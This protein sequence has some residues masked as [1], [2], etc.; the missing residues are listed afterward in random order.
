MNPISIKKTLITSSVVLTL[1]ASN[2]QAALVTNIYGAYTWSTASANFTL[3]SATGATLGGTNDVSLM[4]D[5]NAYNNSVDYIGPGGVSNITASSPTPFFGH[6]WMAH[7]IQIFTP[8]SYSFDTALGGGTVESGIMTA[9][10]GDGQL[11]MHM[12]FDW[13]GNLNIDI[14]MV[15]VPNSIFG[16]GMGRSIN[17]GNCDQTF[18]LQYPTGPLQNCL[19]DGAKLGP[20]GKPAGNKVWMLAST[21]GNGDGI[22]G[23]PMAAGGPLAGFNANFNANL[24]PTA[25]PVPI[26]AAMWLFNSG[27]FGFLAIARRKKRGPDFI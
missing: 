5:G 7:D 2:V 24:T 9:T 10:V 25:N 11:G 18:S 15:F 23:I 27:L 13:K 26:S 12:L 20:D 16:L 21:D 17:M 6:T 19:W 22:M 3:L 1:G 4:W 14:F 8:G